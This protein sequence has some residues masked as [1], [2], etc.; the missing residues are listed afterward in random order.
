MVKNIQSDIDLHQVF[1]M[2]PNGD[3][4][5]IN[6]PNEIESKIEF[7][8]E[9]ATAELYSLWSK[10]VSFRSINEA[11]SD[12]KGSD[13]KSWQVGDYISTR[14]HIPGV[15]NGVESFIEKMRSKL[16]GSRYTSR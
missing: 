3:H 2:I 5:Y 9:V 11:G 16:S 1:A 14:S 10:N 13:A 4:F 8:N 12:Y 7:N 15:I 6:N